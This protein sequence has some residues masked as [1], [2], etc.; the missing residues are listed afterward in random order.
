MAE[1]DWLPEAK[2]DLQ[3][4]YG[5][6]AGHSP[7]A[8]KRAVTTI[9]A[10]AGDLSGFPEVGAPWEPDM[11]YRE[12]VVPFGARAY[13]LRYRLFQGRVVIARVWH[14]LEARD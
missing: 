4:L 11:A 2:A 3:R 6:I 10:R 8:A 13:V 9:I 5:F 12:L 14:G 7:G 1:V